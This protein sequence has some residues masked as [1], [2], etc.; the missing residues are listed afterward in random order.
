[1]LFSATTTKKTEDL[2]AVALKKE[3]IYISIEVKNK[4]G[5]ATVAGLEQGSPLLQ[6]TPRSTFTGWA[7]QP[8]ER[9][10]RATP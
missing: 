9:G 1:M 4:L 5:S 3:P 8:G 6:M 7:G 10:A 2:V